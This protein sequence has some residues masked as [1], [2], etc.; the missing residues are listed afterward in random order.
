[1][2]LSRLATPALCPATPLGTHGGKY[3]CIILAPSTT[4]QPSWR[5]WAR[6]LRSLR[7]PAST[8]RAQ[9]PYRLRSGVFIRA[10]R[11]LGLVRYNPPNAIGAYRM[12]VRHPGAAGPPE[13]SDSA[14]YSAHLGRPHRRGAALP[15][16]PSTMISRILPPRAGFCAIYPSQMRKERSVNGARPRRPTGRYGP[17]KFRGSPWGLGVPD[18]VIRSP[19][20]RL[21]TH[22][23]R[24]PYFTASALGDSIRCH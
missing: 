3:T 6:W 17:P 23:R 13:S 5:G 19:Y 12:A 10:S 18:R 2:R 22:L 7:I 16:T 21:Y 15:S 14:S 4:N 1:M 11:L 24:S 8:D 9:V 20:R